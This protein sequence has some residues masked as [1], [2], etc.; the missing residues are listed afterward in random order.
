VG[1]YWPFA[2]GTKVRHANLLLELIENTPGTRYVLIPN[3]YIG[4][5]KVGFMPEWITREWMARRGSL[6]FR[7]GQLEESRCSLLGY[8]PNSLRVNG[9][10]MPR[11]FLRVH[12]QL[13]VGPEGYDAGAKIL[14]DFFMTEL[15]QFDKPELIPLGRKII[16]LCRSRASV[17]E[18]WDVLPQ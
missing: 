13:E 2:T 8:T 5:Y 10:E 1:S 17:E 14:Y 4:A 11:G 6:R 9:Q 16:G 7:P 3:Q 12:D 15:E 18:F